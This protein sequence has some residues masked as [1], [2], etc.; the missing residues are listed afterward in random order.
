MLMQAAIRHSTPCTASTA[1]AEHT[2]MHQLWLCKFLLSQAQA[3]MCSAICHVLAMLLAATRVWQG[4]L[5][6]LN[7]HL[8]QTIDMLCMHPPF[9]S[10]ASKEQWTI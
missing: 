7:P 10:I 6:L 3:S 1:S 4:L 5:L 2:P 9:S 8:L